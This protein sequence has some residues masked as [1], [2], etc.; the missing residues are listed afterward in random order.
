MGFVA[1]Q[2]MTGCELT[3]DF[4]KETDRGSGTEAMRL[5]EWGTGL[6]PFVVGY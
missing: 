5:Q 2:D 3:F 1:M 4:L 6:G